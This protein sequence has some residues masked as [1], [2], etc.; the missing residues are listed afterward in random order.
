MKF[1]YS[2][3]IALKA[4]SVKTVYWRQ[5]HGSVRAVWFQRRAIS[6]SQQP[7][8]VPVQTS[9]WQYSKIRKNIRQTLHFMQKISEYVCSLTLTAEVFIVS[10]LRHAVGR[11]MYQET[12]K[13]WKKCYFCLQTQTPKYL[14]GYNAQVIYPVGSCDNCPLGSRHHASNNLTFLFIFPCGWHGAAGR[15]GDRV[16]LK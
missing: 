4:I 2:T 1:I 10:Y 5:Y 11:S 7:P 9:N 12:G 16:S 8:A 15:Q 3:C 6:C 13:K 14:R